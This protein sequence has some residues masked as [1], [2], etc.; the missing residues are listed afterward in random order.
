L[1][2]LDGAIESA[3]DMVIA[4]ETGI[5]VLAADPATAGRPLRLW[6]RVRSEC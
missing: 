2:R 6:Q 3:S 1:F 5:A 4:D